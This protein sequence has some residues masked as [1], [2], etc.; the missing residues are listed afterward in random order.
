M[1]TRDEERKLEDIL[2]DSIYTY[3]S[4][5]GE[6]HPQVNEERVIEY[7]NELLAPKDAEIERLKAGATVALESLDNIDAIEW[8]ETV[9]KARRALRQTLEETAYDNP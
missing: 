9:Y 7:I 8:E 6:D 4:N 5:G 1:M 3:T 2:Q